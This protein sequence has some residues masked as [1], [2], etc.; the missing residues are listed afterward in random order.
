MSNIQDPA[1]DFHASL[2]IPARAKTCVVCVKIEGCSKGAVANTPAAQ[3]LRIV[4]VENF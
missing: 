2:S 3:G 1:N 4:G